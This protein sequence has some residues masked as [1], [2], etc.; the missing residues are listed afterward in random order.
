MQEFFR[1][2]QENKIASLQAKLEIARLK[3]QINDVNGD[4]DGDKWWKTI[5]QNASVT[6]S[7]ITV[8]L[9]FLLYGAYPSTFNAIMRGLHG[10]DAPAISATDA[11][12]FQTVPAQNMAY[13]VGMLTGG[14][15]GA[16]AAAAKEKVSRKKIAPK[17]D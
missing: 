5:I 16:G 4:E 13:L 8:I 1:N 3:A 15:L 9:L 10:E 7:I 6:G 12:D 17:E 11:K 2:R 14:T